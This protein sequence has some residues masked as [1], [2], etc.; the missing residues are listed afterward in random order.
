MQ[1]F[2]VFRGFGF[3]ADMFV[4]FELKIPGCRSI[5]WIGIRLVGFGFCRLVLAGPMKPYKPVS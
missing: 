4:S 5:A 2:R 1:A 3:T